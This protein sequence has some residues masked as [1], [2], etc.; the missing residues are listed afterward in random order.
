MI[1]FDVDGT[2]IQGEETDWKSF[3]DSFEAASGSPFEPNF[4][5][6]L[7]EVTAKAIVHRALR[8]RP[9]HERNQIESEVRAGFL[10]R[11]QAA[12]RANPAVFPSTNGAV[13]LIRYLKQSN[14]PLAIATGD[15]RETIS[16]KM[17]AAQI[18]FEDVP[19]VT[20]SE[21][22]ARADIIA[23][24]IERAGGTLKDAIYVGDGPWDYRACR[25]LGIGFI[26][27]GH[28]RDHLLSLGA[29][30]ALPD[31]S[32]IQFLEV[33]ELLRAARKQIA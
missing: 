31:L 10:R 1:V 18:P 11:L 32:R 20:A 4:F 19:M 5:E 30:Y 13:E 28:R 24:A 25:K 27:V 3:G 23:A 26:G 6:N 22:L 16:F 21:F 8:S 9:E 7:T 12:H 14:I 2:L 15:W 33:T 17:T 29:P